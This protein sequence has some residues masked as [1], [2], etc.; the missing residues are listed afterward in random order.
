MHTADGEFHHGQR[1]RQ[2]HE[3]DRHSHTLTAGVEES[4]AEVEQESHDGAQH[5]AQHHL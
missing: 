2:Q 3:G 4:L 1:H 5:Q